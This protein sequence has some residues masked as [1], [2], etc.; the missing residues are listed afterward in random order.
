MTKRIEL[1]RHTDN[2][3][4]VLSPDGVRTAVEIGGGL[5]RPYDLLVS[6]GAQRATQTAACFLSGL[7]AAVHGGVIV[8][9]RFRSEH[10]DRWKAAYAETG[11][12]HIA[13]FLTSA[14]DL[15]K[16]EGEQ[17]AEA[18]QRVAA[19]IP[20]EGCALVVGHSPMHEAAV[21]GLTGETIEPLGK[22]RAVVL[23]LEAGGQARVES[24]D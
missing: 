4:D 24:R 12:G 17:F 9:A 15:V 14:P 16:A 19:L 3:G 1:R 18:I 22:G 23:V 21:F 2:D 11:S 10:E 20:D 13:D 8:D 6:S 7:G 5:S